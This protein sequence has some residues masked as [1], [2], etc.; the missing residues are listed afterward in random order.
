MTRDMEKLCSPVGY[1]LEIRDMT[2]HLK[3]FL[4]TYGWTT[5]LSAIS[6]K[7]FSHPGHTYLFLN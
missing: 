3:Y 7:S 5:E 2:G 1:H 6:F 4:D